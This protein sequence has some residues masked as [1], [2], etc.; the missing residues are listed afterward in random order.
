VLTRATTAGGGGFLAKECVEGLLRAAMSTDGALLLEV[1]LATE[2]LEGLF[3]DKAGGSAE[4]FVLDWLL[5]AAASGGGG[6]VFVAEWIDVDEGLFR[7]L[8]AVC[9]LI[10]ECTDV[11]EG[12]FKAAAA[13]VLAP[14]VVGAACT[15]AGAS[16]DFFSIVTG[17]T[18]VGAA[19]FAGAVA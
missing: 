17:S 3:S 2:V 14:V 16:A 4:S 19:T 15:G 18:T 1:S 9:A 5:R 12:L 10:V 13:L 6:W 11:V 8:A 7:A